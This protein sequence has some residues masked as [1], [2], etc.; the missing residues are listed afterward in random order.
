MSNISDGLQIYAIQNSYYG[1]VIVS[2]FFLCSLVFLFLFKE[3]YS[4]A[5]NGKITL[6]KKNNN[7]L[8]NCIT[9]NYNFE[10][11]YY[12]EYE[13]NNTLFQHQ[14][15][16]DSNSQPPYI[17]PTTI[18]YA[19]NNPNNYNIG[20][21]NPSYIKYI[22]FIFFLILLFFAILNVYNVT[23][24]KSYAENQG[25]TSIMNSYNSYNRPGISISL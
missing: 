23:T 7:E 10:C 13:V 9:N 5:Q 1:L 14:Y 8:V 16:V 11:Q 22:C 21:I 18:Y 20:I 19:E 12:V 3:K 24:N 15:Y 25:S 4:L 6:K 2:I 17:G